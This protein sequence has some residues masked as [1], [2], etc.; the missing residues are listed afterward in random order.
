[1]GRAFRQVYRGRVVSPAKFI[2]TSTNKTFVSFTLAVDN[3]VNGKETGFINCSYFPA[4]DRAPTEDVVAMALAWITNDE[5]QGL[6][7]PNVG[8]YKSVEVTVEGQLSLNKSEVQKGGY[9]LNLRYT[10]VDIHDREIVQAVKSALNVDS[11]Q[12][13]P[14]PTPAAPPAANN[15]AVASPTV[16]P[17]SNQ[18][19]TSAPAVTSVPNTAPAPAAAPQAPTSGP[20]EGEMF[21]TADGHIYKVENGQHV[22]VGSKGQQPAAA[23]QQQPAP[24]GA[25]I[26]Q[27]LQQSTPPSTANLG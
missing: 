2:N 15:T 6:S 4:K 26:G 27:V 19:P 11:N 25:T 23:P 9:Y 21:E 1:M 3:L 14:A 24:Q 5:R 18:V 8:T 12:S 13:D 10:N 20:K 17:T 7:I 16:A 22:Y